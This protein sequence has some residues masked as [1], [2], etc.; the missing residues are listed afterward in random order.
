MSVARFTFGPRLKAHRERQGITLQDIAESTKIGVSLLAALERNDVAQW[1]K[2]IFRRAFL[3]SYARAIDVPFEPTWAEF[4]RLF[5]EDGSAATPSPLE[6]SELRLTLAA[7][8]RRWFAPSS[9]GLIAALADLALVLT[10]SALAS[11][12]TGASF[13]VLLACVGTAYAAAGTVLT[14]GSPTHAWLQMTHQRST[15]AHDTAAISAPQVETAERSAPAPFAIEELRAES[16]DVQHASPR[17]R[18][19]AVPSNRPVA[20]DMRERRVADR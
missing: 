9:R 3:R 7:P 16:H 15:A 8:A 20:T 17:P 10:V 6:S 5:P 19:V 11:V 18:I 14:G 2:G 12:I 13:W 1:P 4:V